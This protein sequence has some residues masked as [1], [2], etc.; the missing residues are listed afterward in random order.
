M[1]EIEACK[2]PAQTDSFVH[3]ETAD[4]Y[5]CSAPIV[6]KRR[7]PILAKAHPVLNLGA[8]TNAHPLNL[9]HKKLFLTVMALHPVRAWLH[10]RK[11]PDHTSTW[12]EYTVGQTRS[13][14]PAFCRVGKSLRH[15]KHDTRL[16]QAISWELPRT[17]V[18][19]FFFTR[20]MINFLPNHIATLDHN[21][22]SHGRPQ[23]FF[24]GGE[25]STFC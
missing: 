6:R 11:V 12:N 9:K 15:K 8:L 14:S 1:F 23:K 20:C 2:H 18:P 22:Y 3:Y 21:M 24:Q 10:L 7:H 13:S 19:E 17:E 25:T 5:M 4:A 16:S